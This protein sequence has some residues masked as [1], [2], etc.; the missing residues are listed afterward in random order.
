MLFDATSNLDRSD[1]KLF[2]II[3]PSPIGGLPLGSLIITREDESTITEG[4]ELFK[5]L[6]SD[7]S[8]YGRGKRTKNYID[9]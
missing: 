3:T 5:E 7:E 9:R 1:T 8:F 2:H 6:L 4:L